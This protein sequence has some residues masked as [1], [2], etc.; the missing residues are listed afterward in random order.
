MELEKE[1][2]NIA[3]QIKATCRNG[4]KY[5]D[6]EYDTERYSHML[7]LSNRITALI[8]GKE[9][10]VI[11]NIQVDDKEYTTPKVDARAVIFDDNDRILL[12]KERADGRWAIPGGWIDVGLSP[13]EAAVKEVKEET[14][15]DVE[16]V[17]LL[18]IL[19]K[20]KH[21]HPPALFHAFQIFILCKITGGKFNTAFD[22]LDKGFF[23]QTDL[24]PLSEERTLKYQ[25]DLMFEYHH[26]L[27]KKAIS[28]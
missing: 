24:P 2:L 5:N 19:D 14:G 23:A 18:A 9:V 15:L 11:E 13:Q 20:N 17:R 10:S 22:I 8:S 1:L 26:D 27:L 7:G 6:N 16:A 25:I 21:P 4:L 28:D 3:E 12:V